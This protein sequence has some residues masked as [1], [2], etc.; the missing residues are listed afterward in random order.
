MELIELDTLNTISVIATQGTASIELSTLQRGRI[1]VQRTNLSVQHL[2]PSN[3]NDAVKCAREH[4]LRRSELDQSP[5]RR[6]K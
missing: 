2:F 5:F 1:R 6:A 4:A 3:D